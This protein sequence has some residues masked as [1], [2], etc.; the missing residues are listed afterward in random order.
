[1]FTEYFRYDKFLNFKLNKFKKII[2]KINFYHNFNFNKRLR[3]NY[4][5]LD[6]N[7]YSLYNIKV[8]IF[9]KDK[10]IYLLKD[11]QYYY[12]SNYNNNFYHILKLVEN[13]DVK[14]IEWN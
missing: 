11:N 5:V 6:Y 1:M 14:R 3:Y 7:N 12:I 10:E 2:S 9:L 8:L 13:L 4:L